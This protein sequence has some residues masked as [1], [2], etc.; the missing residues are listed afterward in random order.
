MAL[1][2]A[3]VPITLRVE[4]VPVIDEDALRSRVE[5]VVADALSKLAAQPD[6]VQAPTASVSDA[7]TVLPVFESVGAHSAEPRSSAYMGG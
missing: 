5:A 1:N 7:T 6:A 2:I 4:V 3:S